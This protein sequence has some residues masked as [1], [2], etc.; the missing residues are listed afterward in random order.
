MPVTTQYEI[1]IEKRGSSFRAY[2][3]ELPGCTATGN[4]VAEAEAGVRQVLRA[5]NPDTGVFHDGFSA[6]Q[7]GAACIDGYRWVSPSH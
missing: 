4:S 7:G 1:V 3:P 5:G 2:V 6:V